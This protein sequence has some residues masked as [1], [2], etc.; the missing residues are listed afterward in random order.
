MCAI[1]AFRN[2]LVRFDFFPATQFL[3]YKGEIEYRTAT[4]GTFT[5]LITVLFCLL[6]FNALVDIIDKK[7]VSL[8]TDTQHQGVPAA[9]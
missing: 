7:N 1:R 4:G 8:Q 6:F 9:S 5:I 3:R 2:V